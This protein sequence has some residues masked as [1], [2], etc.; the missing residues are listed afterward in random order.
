MN[1]EFYSDAYPNCKIGK[2]HGVPSYI[3]C[4]ACI[5]RGENKID[6]D[7]NWG[8]GDMI[9]SVAQPI[10]RAIDS[11][12]GTDIQNCGGCKKRREMLNEMF[13]ISVE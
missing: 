9:H 3:H 2:Y 13:P 1:C 5:D 10:A 6:Q 8:L 7:I 11:T 4:I 12:L